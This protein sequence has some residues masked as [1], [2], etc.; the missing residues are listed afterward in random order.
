MSKNNDN[1][2]KTIP[3][4]LATR[5]A[6]MTDI[7]SAA[8]DSGFED[9]FKDGKR[10]GETHA[11]RRRRE[12]AEAWNDHGQPLVTGI[13]NVIADEPGQTGMHGEPLNEP[14]PATPKRDR[15]KLT[16]G[17]HRVRQLLDTKQFTAAPTIAGL[18]NLRTRTVRSY[19][20]DLQ[21][22]GYKIE[23]TR[24]SGGYRGR[25]RGR[26]G[27]RVGYRLAKTG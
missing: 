16:S 4:A 9:G 27:Y 25:G 2:T 13:K 17:H 10:E 6:T 21:Q 23:K 19:I 26:I 14:I 5:L 8:Y 1:I 15:E 18:C 11:L 22:H 20:R 12:L 7:V 24:L 3:A